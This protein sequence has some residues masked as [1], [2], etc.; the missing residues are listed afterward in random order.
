M[1]LPTIFKDGQLGKNLGYT[2]GIP[3]LDKLIGGVKRKSM[4]VIGAAS[5]VGKTTFVDFSFVLQPY[6]E[7]LSKGTLDNIDWVYYS[8]EIDRVS[9]EFK[10]AAF[11]FYHDYGIHKFRYRDVEY[12]ISDEYLSGQLK[13]E[14]DTDK[15]VPVSPE[16]EALLIKIYQERIVPLFGEYDQHGKQIKRGKIEFFE[17]AENPT[18]LY[19]YLIKK[20]KSE[21]EPIYDYYDKVDDNGNTTEKERIIGYTPHNPLKTTIVITDHI[22]KVGDERGFTLKQR[23]DKW[24]DY[25]VRLRN[26]YFFTFIHICHLNRSMDVER[27]K[28]MGSNIFPSRD[29]FMDS[30][31]LAQDADYVI[32]L[33]NAMDE[34]YRLKEHLGTV[35]YDRAG[36]AVYPK[37]RSIHLVDARKGGRATPAHIKVNMWGHINYYTKLGVEL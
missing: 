9:K 7:A 10:F 6:L 16:H 18:G 34:T 3:P 33:F 5:K 31:N 27:L 28:F 23:M 17:E 12:E 30:S 1:N 21:G 32:T 24:L 29:D 2:T 14:L 15:I 8:W 25:T 36:K 37:Y 26:R 22:R 19:Y 4:Y 13:D 35:L 11:F 20:A